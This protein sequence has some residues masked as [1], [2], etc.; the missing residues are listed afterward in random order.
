M[1]EVLEPPRW[2]AVGLVIDQN[3]RHFLDGRFGLVQDIV[4]WLKAV[5]LF[6]AAVDERMILREPSPENLRRHKTW[7]AS[8]IVEGERLVTEVQSR[9]GMAAGA[10]R[11]T[12]EDV[13]ATVENLRSDERMWHSTPTAEQKA[14]LLQ[15]VFHVEKPRT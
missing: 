8:L 4:S 10:V 6:R 5:E 13:E 11:F 12:L 15:A 14:E 1:N 7:I 9:G 3:R 2:E